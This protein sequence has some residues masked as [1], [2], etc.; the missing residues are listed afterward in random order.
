MKKIFILSLIALFAFSCRDEEDNK[1]IVGDWNIK[2]FE[3][4]VTE[5]GKVL[6]DQKWIDIGEFN[7]KTNGTGNIILIRAI[8]GLP[9]ESG[10]VWAIDSTNLILVRFDDGRP[11]QKYSPSYRGMFTYLGGSSATLVGTKFQVTER[12]L[13]LQKK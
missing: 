1:S 9:K 8:T 5:D 10:F 6:T 12:E 3:Y 2:S 13:L 11:L 4:K 7:F